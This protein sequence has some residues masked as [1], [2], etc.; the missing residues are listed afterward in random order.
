M[1][2]AAAAVP[3]MPALWANRIDLDHGV[4]VDPGRS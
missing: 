3:P 4:S 2:D 1:L